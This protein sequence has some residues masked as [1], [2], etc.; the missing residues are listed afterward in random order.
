[1]PVSGGRSGVGG[2]CN[3]RSAAGHCARL[4]CLVTTQWRRERSGARSIDGLTTPVLFTLE[5]AARR[6]LEVRGPAPV[7][8]GARR[9]HRTRGTRAGHRPLVRPPRRPQ[10]DAAHV[11]GRH[12]G[13]C[14]AVTTANGALAGRGYATCSGAVRQGGPYTPDA[15]MPD[16]RC[17]TASSLASRPVTGA[18]GSGRH[19]SSGSRRAHCRHRQHVHA[20]GASGG[21]PGRSGAI[22]AEVLA[23]GYDHRAQR[24]RATDARRLTSASASRCTA[25]TSKAWRRARV[26]IER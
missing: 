7:V 26:G 16:T 25:R 24:D 14:P 2:L 3:R 13:A 4:R 15:F 21:L 6:V 17:N 10:V 19:A 9:S 5:G 18:G 12:D 23:T 1:M 8:A 20:P 22:V 11:A